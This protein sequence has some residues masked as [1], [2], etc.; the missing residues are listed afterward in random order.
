M[1][2]VV[3]LGSGNI[4]TRVY[5]LSRSDLHDSELLLFSIGSHGPNILIAA[6][7]EHIKDHMSSDPAVIME[8]TILIDNKKIRKR[9]TEHDI[10]VKCIGFLAS[11]HK[12]LNTVAD[13]NDVEGQFTKLFNVNG[14]EIK[15][16]KRVIPFSPY[17]ERNII[18]RDN[19]RMT[20][21]YGDMLW[22]NNVQYPIVILHFIINTAVEY[23]VMTLIRSSRSTLP[24]RHG[25]DNVIMFDNP[26]P[27]DPIPIPI[28]LFRGPNADMP[29]EA[30]DMTLRFEEIHDSLQ[31][32]NKSK[33][34][35]SGVIFHPTDTSSIIWTEMQ[36]PTALVREGTYAIAHTYPPTV[37]PLTLLST[38]HE[39]TLEELR[40]VTTDV[41]EYLFSHFPLKDTNP[42]P[43]QLINRCDAYNVQASL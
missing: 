15:Q 36:P 7:I 24:I 33:A 25:T 20:N 8:A 3:S 41:V 37:D 2:M 4:A 19:K 13:L 28:A 40:N 16:D 34:F 12:K 17:V 38:I 9:I 27:F 32:R 23:K 5:D 35:R 42:V 30:A 1:S 18:N 29:R 43:Q 22:C 14:N 11:M 39:P 6:P 26:C 31:T 21:T 10:E